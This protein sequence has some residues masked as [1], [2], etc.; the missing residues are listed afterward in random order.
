MYKNSKTPCS[1]HLVDKYFL[2]L[3]ELPPV[4]INGRMGVLDELLGKLV[5]P[6]A[7]AGSVEVAALAI[8]LTAG[9]DPDNGVND[10]V[11]GVGGGSGSE[12][13]GGN[14]A[15]LTPITRK[16]LA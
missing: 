10:G 3:P 11:V 15:P 8:R 13:G 16:M 12:S 2:Y 4:L 7:G 1:I 5:V 9:L 14:V 6:M